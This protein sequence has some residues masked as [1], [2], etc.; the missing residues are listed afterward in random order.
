MPYIIT[1]THGERDM[2]WPRVT[3]RAVATLDEA[4][5]AAR[6]SVNAIDVG[7]FRECEQA[8]L[9][10]EHGGT[11]GPL[12]DG[13]VIEVEPATYE[14]LIAALGITYMAHFRRAHTDAATIAAYNAAQ[15]VTA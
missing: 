4:R 13:T 1:T 3:R 5:E 8:E 11:I 2:R 7:L 12:P 15:G 14:A 10:P 9:L 6:E